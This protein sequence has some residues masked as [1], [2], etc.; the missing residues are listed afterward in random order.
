VFKSENVYDYVGDYLHSAFQNIPD[1]GLV[2]GS[3]GRVVDF[4]T[5][6]KALNEGYPIAGAAVT[7]S[8]DG[9]PHRP[10]IKGRFRLQT[11]P[12]VKYVN[13]GSILMPPVDF[14]LDNGV[15]GTRACRQQVRLFTQSG[16][17]RVKYAN[18]VLVCMLIGSSNFGVGTYS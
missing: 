10:S 4:I 16:V 18:C 8:D 11:W 5:P 12:L 13:S 1:A 3:I 17:F 15:G 6:E 2:N 14:A 9:K 7:I